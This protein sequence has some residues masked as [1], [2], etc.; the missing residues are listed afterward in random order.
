[1]KTTA[2]PLLRAYR[3]VELTDEIDHANGTESDC[4]EFRIPNWKL[5]DGFRG[6]VASD[7]SRL[8]DQSSLR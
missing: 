3:E 1:M 5:S 8:F 6:K 2:K 4:R 7:S